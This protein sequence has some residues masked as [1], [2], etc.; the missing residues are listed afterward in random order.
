MPAPS[1]D[2]SKFTRDDL[3]RIE[4]LTNNRPRKTLRLGHLG[5]S[6]RR[7]SAMM[8]NIVATSPRIRLRTCGADPGSF[9][10]RRH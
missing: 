2:L 7:R 8:S 1:A 9:F 5:A 3:D 4:H 6:V 10:F